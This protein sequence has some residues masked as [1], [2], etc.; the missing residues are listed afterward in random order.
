MIRDRLVLGFHDKVTKLRLL[1]KDNLSLNKA[2]NICHSNE[3]ASQQLKSMNL[4]GNEEE[5]VNFVRHG[6][7]RRRRRPFFDKEKN[8]P[9]DRRRREASQDKCSWFGRRSSH[10]LEDCPG[11]GQKCNKWRKLNLFAA[12]FK[13][14]QKDLVHNVGH[15]TGE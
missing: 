13:F 12:V 10:K 4:D 8:N 11:R 14:K 2:I 5:D 15:K 3:I 9:G 7:Q 1:K 6:P